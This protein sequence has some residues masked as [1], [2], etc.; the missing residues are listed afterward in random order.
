MDSI[1]LIA[2]PACDLLHRKSELLRGMTAHCRRCKTELYSAPAQSLD[3]PLALVLCGLIVFAVANLYPFLTLKLEGRIEETVLVSGIVSLYQQGRVV[4]AGLVLVTGIICPL[5]QLAGLLYI[6]FPLRIGRVPPH[7]GFVYRWV[8]RIQPWAMIEIFLLGTLVS[9]VK[10]AHLAG[11]VPGVALFAFTALI[12]I[13]PAATAG[14]HPDS[15]WEQIP[16]H[17]RR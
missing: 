17:T 7:L 4:L 14:L 10:L 15:I 11:I 3:R 16:I 8:Q 12:F 5:A 13:V 9:I 2:C 6:L 1:N